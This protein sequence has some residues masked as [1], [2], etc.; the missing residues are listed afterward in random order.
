MS[1]R[2]REGIKDLALFAL[3]LL[4]VAVLIAAVCGLIARWLETYD[5]EDANPCET[6]MERGRRR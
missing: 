1:D 3:E 2:P 4:V 5:D 6:P